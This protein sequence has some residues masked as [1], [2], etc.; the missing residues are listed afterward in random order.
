VGL[1]DLALDP[2]TN[3]VRRL[4]I[5]KGHMSGMISAAKFAEMPH[6]NI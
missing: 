4:A 2:Q 5:E 3:K 1:D 6:Y